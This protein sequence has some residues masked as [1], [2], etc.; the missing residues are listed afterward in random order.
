VTEQQPPAPQRAWNP[1]T[2]LEARLIARAWKDEAFAQ[3]LRADPKGAVQREMAAL[4]PGAPGAAL[5]ADLEVRVVEE[6]PTVLYLVLPP[7]PA[8]PAG[9]ELSDADLEAVAGG[10]GP[11]A[12]GGLNTAMT[13]CFQRGC[14]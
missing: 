11:V 9:E 3:Q 1:R 12:V 13:Y 10:A 7:K 2:Q 4:F 14:G 5:P 8:G 6:T